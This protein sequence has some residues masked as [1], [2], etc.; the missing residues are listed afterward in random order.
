MQK[1]QAQA[2]GSGFVIA[3]EGSTGY[4]VTNAHVVNPPE[5]ASVSKI[6]VVFK[7]GD[8]V[9]GN[10]YSV[11]LARDL[12]LLKITG[13]DKLPPQLTLADSDKLE[14]GQWSIAIGEPFELRQSVS[15]GIVSGFHRAESVGNE[16]GSQQEFNDLLQTSAP[17]N[18]GNSG[19][20]LVDTDGEVIGVNQIVASP[21]AGAQGIGFAIPS[22]TVRAI[23][24][25]LEKTPGT[26]QGTNSGFIG[27]VL[28]PLNPSIRAQLN[29]YVGPGVLINQVNPNTPA[30]KAGL[31]PGDVIQAVN[32][33]T[34]ADVRQ[35]VDAIKAVKPGQSISL[36]VW[37]NGV[38]KFVSV[39]VEERPAMY[40]V[41]QP[42]P[43]ESP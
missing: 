23:V 20:P 27:V 5:E 13:Y 33:K 19:G 28:S 42:N 4:V 15:L 40:G 2:S 37:S 24:A 17:I 16:G 38:R 18:P 1:F 41:E 9:T 34:A 36:S 22:N 26:H 35:V 43:T 10:V 8:R 32:G 7:N 12:A 6:T 21:Q 3:R 29:N 31:N 39:Q 25:E 30:E 14:A 11:N